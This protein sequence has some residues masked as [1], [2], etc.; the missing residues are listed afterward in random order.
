MKPNTWNYRI[1]IVAERKPTADNLPANPRQRVQMRCFD[2]VK[3][4]TFK[5]NM[6]DSD[7]D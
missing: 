7:K 4:G 5:P 3:N 1:P 2:E 6:Y